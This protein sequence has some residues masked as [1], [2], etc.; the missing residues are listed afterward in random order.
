MTELTPTSGVVWR[1]GREEGYVKQLPSGAVARLRA[2]P[3]AKLLEHLGEVPD[4]LTPLVISM[5][6]QG[7]IGNELDKMADSGKKVTDPYE[8]ARWAKET[9]D[10]INMVCKLAFVDPVIVDNPTLDNEIHIDDVDQVDRGFVFQLCTQ[11]AEVL[12]KFRIEETS[13][14][15]GVPDSRNV[16]R[17]AKRSAGS[18]KS[19]GS[20]PTG[21]RRRILRK[22][23][24]E[25]L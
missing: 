21:Q 9:T 3:P 19:M 13:G 24:K 16:R 20:L 12:A 2:I 17:Q 23:T 25:R 6:F 14:M 8:I 7:V 11:P 15:E 5:S 4:R 10:L 22:L 18:G 1:K